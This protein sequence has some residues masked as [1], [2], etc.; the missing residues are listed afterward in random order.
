IGRFLGI[1]EN[2]VDVVPLAV[3]PHFRV[4]N[5]AEKVKAVLEKYGLRRPFFISVSTL[6]PRKN[7]L[8]LLRAFEKLRQ[9][10]KNTLLVLVGKPGGAENE[11]EQFIQE[12]NLR[13]QVKIAGY[14][15]DDDLVCLYNA[16][17]AYVTVS[18][19]EGFGL[20]ALEAMACGLTGLV[21][22]RSSLPEVTGN[23]AL[24]VDPENT[25]AIAEGLLRLSQDGDY[26]SG[27]SRAAHARS[28]HFSIEK[29]AGAMM[30]IFKNEAEG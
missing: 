11:L 15:P 13:D 5:D 22:S 1:P 20:P 19:Y 6:E 30:E 14:V 9:S 12:R 23:T 18:L 17:M 26:R 2:R 28:N 10:D 21:S 27:L 4:L 29:T 25:D 16:A 8:R 7:L 24:L 3:R